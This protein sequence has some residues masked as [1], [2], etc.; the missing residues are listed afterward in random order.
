MPSMTNSPM[1]KKSRTTLVLRTLESNDDELEEPPT[2]GAR[3]RSE[4][5]MFS[6]CCALGIM[7]TYFFVAYGP[8]ILCT[9]FL[10]VSLSPSKDCPNLRSSTKAVFDLIQGNELPSIN[11]IISGTSTKEDAKVIRWLHM[12]KCGQSFFL[13]V[14][15]YACFDLNRTIGLLGNTCYGGAPVKCVRDVVFKDVGMSKVCPRLLPSQKKLL[16][17]PRDRTDDGHLVGLLR[18]PYQRRISSVG[19]ALCGTNHQSP[20]RHLLATASQKNNQPRRGPGR[21]TPKTIP[22]RSK[23]KTMPGRSKP[24]TIPG[25]NKRN[26]VSIRRKSETMKGSRERTTVPGRHGSHSKCEHV[27]ATKVFQQINS[28]MR[29]PQYAAPQTYYLSGREKATKSA[30]RSLDRF[31][32]VGLVEHFNAS[33]CLFHAMLGPPAQGVAPSIPQFTNL[34]PGV[35]T[36]VLKNSSDEHYDVDAIHRIAAKNGKKWYEADALVY[37]RGVHIFRRQLKKFRETASQLPN[38]GFMEYYSSPPP[39]DV[40]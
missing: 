3:S 28:E 15:A 30:L 11:K 5:Q 26:A 17:T 4:F 13:S 32:F 6:V 38:C 24:K 31:L 40:S 22:G 37:Q 2:S 21:S 8:I 16:H 25:R 18:E 36:G 9:Y 20:S 39:Y 1:A 33:I 7:V 10:W 23:P 34:H 12:K 27:T 14:W 19:Q 29:N 35:L